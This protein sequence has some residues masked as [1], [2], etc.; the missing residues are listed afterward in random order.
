[1]VSGLIQFRHFNKQQPCSPGG[2]IS[3][4]RSTWLEKEVQ[5]RWRKKLRRREAK[6]GLPFTLGLLPW[7]GAGSHSPAGVKARA[8][9]RHARATRWRRPL[10]IVAHLMLRRGKSPFSP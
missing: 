3:G 2:W 8:A 5:R 6:S 10:L 1:M 7:M 9:R 4:A